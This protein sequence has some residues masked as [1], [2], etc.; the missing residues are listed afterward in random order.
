VPV[1]GLAANF[2][3]MPRMAPPPLG[4]DIEGADAA[5]LLAAS[6]VFSLL[7]FFSSGITFTFKNHIFK[8]FPGKLSKPLRS[9]HHTSSIA[10]Q[11]ICYYYGIKKIAAM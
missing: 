2:S 8:V 5:L 3:P 1:T 4:S 9:S 7:L 6:F 10:C 11:T